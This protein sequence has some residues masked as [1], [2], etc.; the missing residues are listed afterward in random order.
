M[1]AQ[2][3]AGTNDGFG[4]VAPR[5][6]PLAHTNGLPAKTNQSQADMKAWTQFV[7]TETLD[8]DARET[9][10]HVFSDDKTTV[11]IENYLV[12][13]GV[14]EVNFLVPW[15]DG[16]GQFTFC[17]ISRESE[18][19]LEYSVPPTGPFSV[20]SQP[21]ANAI[22]VE[23]V[24]AYFKNMYRSYALREPGE[25]DAT[26]VPLVHLTVKLCVSGKMSKAQAASRKAR[27]LHEATMAS[28]YTD[29]VEEKRQRLICFE[30][31]ARKEAC[32]SCLAFAVHVGVK[33]VRWRSRCLE[34][35]YSPN[36]TGYLQA[37]AS[38]RASSWP[39][40]AHACS[41]DDSTEARHQSAA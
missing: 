24:I 29:Y 2:R 41:F 23:L 8:A 22:A 25:Y 31:Q 35:M 10:D 9:L 39:M 1:K 20:V 21:L 17:M 30:K 5:V 18:H 6:R 11:L 19:W 32:L 7:T 38:Y 3:M 34:R 14:M 36:G 40:S 16:L 26:F 4:R 12:D 37:R 13:L 15:T 28:Y 33:L 27:V